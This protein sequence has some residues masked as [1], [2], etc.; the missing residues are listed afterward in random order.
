MSTRNK[1][2]LFKQ[3]QNVWLA[4]VVVVVVLVM[5]MMRMITIELQKIIFNETVR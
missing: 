4:F 1:V 5:K 2:N 3:N